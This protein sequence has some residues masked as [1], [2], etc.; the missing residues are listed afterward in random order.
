MAYARENGEIVDMERMD[1]MRWG[2][3]PLTNHAGEPIIDK[4]GNTTVK[5]VRLHK[6]QSNVGPTHGVSVDGIGGNIV[7]AQ[8]KAP[9]EKQKVVDV[10]ESKNSPWGYRLKK[11][12]KKH[13]SQIEVKPRGS[14]VIKHYD[15]KLGVNNIHNEEI[16]NPN[17]PKYQRPNRPD[18]GETYYIPPKPAR[19]VED[20][21]TRLRNA[22]LNRYGAQSPVDNAELDR[23]KQARAA[24]LQ[25]LKDRG[26]RRKQRVNR[27]ARVATV[28]RKPAT[29]K[30]KST[31]V[32]RKPVVAKRKPATVKRKPVSMFTLKLKKKPVA[33]KR[34]TTTKRKSTVKRRGV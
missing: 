21:I 6:I 13:A 22:Q 19:A 18:P 25:K 31:V 16:D 32:K 33:A 28:K 29:M 12:P 10:I 2:V 7:T 14:V 4:N 11:E 27:A 23:I 3:K 30:R 24:E 26:L 20:N 1:A 34:K 15:S 17:H 8:P 5:L 9:K